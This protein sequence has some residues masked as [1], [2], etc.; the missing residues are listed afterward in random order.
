[1]PFCMSSGPARGSTV[2]DTST[3]SAVSILDDTCSDLLYYRPLKVTWAL[4]D[5]ASVA[6][7]LGISNLAETES[8]LE[9][10]VPSSSLG[11]VKI[12]KE[13]HLLRQNRRRV[14]GAYAGS[15]GQSV[16]A[17]YKQ[18]ACADVWCVSVMVHTATIMSVIRFLYV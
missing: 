18:E 7:V 10:Q 4:I 8:Q 17:P 3:V 2:F 15:Y 6:F 9:V 16:G 13:N 1:M 11:L 5:A 12:P 14:N